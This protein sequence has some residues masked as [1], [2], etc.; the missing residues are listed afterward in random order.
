MGASYCEKWFQSGKRPINPMTAADAQAKHEARQPYCALIGDTRG[1][2][3]V[4]SLAGAWVS[5]SFLDERKREYLRYDFKERAP[6]E[7]FLAAAVLRVFEGMTDNVVEVT[8]FAFKETGDGLIERRDLR[9]GQVGERRWSGDARS[10]WERYPNFG[11]YVALCRLERG[12]SI[13]SAAGTNG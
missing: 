6:R 4:L 9:A 13:E 1:P 8:Q 11:D 5:V 2:T 7:L 3:H 10:N 12:M